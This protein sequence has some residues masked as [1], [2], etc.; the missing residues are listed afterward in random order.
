[1]ELILGEFSDLKSFLEYITDRDLSLM[2]QIYDLL[3]YTFADRALS[4]AESGDIEAMIVCASKARECKEMA[5]V[6]EKGLSG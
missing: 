1:M 6:I 2:V 3:Y 5:I 4:R